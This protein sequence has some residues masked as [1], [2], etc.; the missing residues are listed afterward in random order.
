MDA[1]AC[2][3]QRH[4]GLEAAMSWSVEQCRMTE[5][6]EPSG[7]S[8]CVMVPR[9]PG[10]DNESTIMDGWIDKSEMEWH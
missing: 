5:G 9:H 7:F 8:R 6:F 2:Y 1:V 3:A 10:L 4:H